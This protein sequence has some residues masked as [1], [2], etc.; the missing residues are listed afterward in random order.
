MS[1]IDFSRRSILIKE[2]LSPRELRRKGQMTCHLK[3]VNSLR[4]LYLSDLAL[5]IFLRQLE[6]LQHLKTLANSKTPFVDQDYVICQTNGNPYEETHMAKKF[7]MLTEQLGYPRCRIHDLRH[8]TASNVYDL[9]GDYLAVSRI[10]G[11][12]IKGL[13]KTLGS[14]K[15]YESMTSLYIHVQPSR[16]AEAVKI[17]HNEVKKLQ[18]ALNKGK[19]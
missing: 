2:Q 3:T 18:E 8:S 19:S 17:H 1:C 14:S 5:G 10:L 6:R 13:E 7:H 4:T 11:H 12:T 9:T 16:T 15:L